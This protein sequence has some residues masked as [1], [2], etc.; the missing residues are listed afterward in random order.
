MAAF[1]V[2]VSADTDTGGIPLMIGTVEL[3][4][5]LEPEFGG[6]GLLL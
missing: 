2:V 6:G 5:A 1:G 3:V 4:G